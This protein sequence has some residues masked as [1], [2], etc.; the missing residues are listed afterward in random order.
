MR[1]QRSLA[2]DHGSSELYS[3]PEKGLRRVSRP[4]ENEMAAAYE[5]S[6]HERSGGRGKPAHPHK[7]HDDQNA[8]HA[9]GG[10]FGANTELIFALLSGACLALG[11]GLSW[12][13]TASPAVSTGLYLAAYV[14]GGFFTLREAFQSLKQRRFEIDTLM[15]VAAA[16]AAMLGEFA[17]G[18]FSSFFSAL[19]IHS[20]ITPWGV[21]N[22]RS[23][24]LPNSHRRQQSFAV[25]EAPRK[26]RSKPWS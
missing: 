26:C 14:F 21:P 23:K 19:A 13:D 25:P 11:F 18:A 1:P 3:V 12:T 7:E 10:V 6:A 2:T 5:D 4:I 15:L 16:G 20:K 8:D 24:H 9:H 17:E 22:V